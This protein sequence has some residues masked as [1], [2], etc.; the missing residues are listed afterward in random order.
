MI[1]KT[2]VGHELARIFTNKPDRY[3]KTKNHLFGSP[4]YLYKILIPFV[5][6]RVNS[7]Q[8]PV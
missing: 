3:G 1:Q 7:W 6:I 2:L 8:K 5:F 4:R